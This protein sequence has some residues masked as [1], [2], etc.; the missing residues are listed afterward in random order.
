MVKS[1]QR[2]YSYFPLTNVA[3]RLRAMDVRGV[4]HPAISLF[5]HSEYHK[6]CPECSK[7]INRALLA[8]WFYEC[9]DCKKTFP[10]YIFKNEECNVQGEACPN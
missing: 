4:R 10:L 2:V 7:P 5:Y 3:E 8:G 6:P 9:L 1:T